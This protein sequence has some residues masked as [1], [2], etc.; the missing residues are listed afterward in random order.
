M[1]ICIT[2]YNCIC[3]IGRNIDEVYKNALSGISDKFEYRQD[4]IKN[5]TLCIGVVDDNDVVIDNEDYNLKCNRLLVECIYPIKNYI[6]SLIIKHGKNR[7]GIVVATTNTG[8]NEFEQTQKEIHSQIGNSAMFLREYLGLESYYTGVSTACTSGIKAFSIARDLIKSGFNDAVIVAGTDTLSNVP[9]FGFSALEVLSGEK[10]N[11]LS[12]NRSGI[13]IGEGTAVFVV[14][15][16]NKGIEIMGIGET[17]DTYHSTSPDPNAVEAIRAIKIALDDAQI[18]QD[19]V[20][21]IN[22]HG[23]GS[24]ANDITETKAISQIFDKTYVSATKPLTGHCLGA[25]ACVETA[26]CCALIEKGGYYK[27]IYDG[28]YDVSLPNLNIYNPPKRTNICMNNAF[29]FGGTNAIMIIG[30]QD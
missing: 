14:E 24:I 11:P 10:T 22:L 8:V 5:K 18:A 7:I 1:S 13:N 28:E 25:A 19:K 9:L 23:T 26:L 4:V 6:D 30:R 17:T 27:H 12:K 20:D 29:G 16:S 2:K 15:K 3:N 21:Y